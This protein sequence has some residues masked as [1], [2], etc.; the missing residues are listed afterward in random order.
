MEESRAL[1]L[2]LAGVVAQVLRPK[3]REVE[4]GSLL[5]SRGQ[6]G[7][8]RETLLPAN[9]TAHSPTLCLSRD[10]PTLA[11]IPAHCPGLPGNCLPARGAPLLGYPSKLH[12]RLLPGPDW[13]I[14]NVGR[15]L[16]LVF[17]FEGCELLVRRKGVPRGGAGR[18]RE[19]RS[20]S[21]AC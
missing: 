19:M 1:R 20:R 12:S 21:L 6:P 16:R 13:F 9:Q 17:R 18:G 5:K 8:P 15:V 14:A 3:C 11:W 7:L 2:L 4:A 10:V